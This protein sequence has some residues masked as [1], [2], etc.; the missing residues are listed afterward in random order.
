MCL[1]ILQVIDKL[2][3]RIERGYVNVLRIYWM[4]GSTGFA[5]DWQK[6]IYG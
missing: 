1:N 3:R 5:I 6:N 4:I 2:E